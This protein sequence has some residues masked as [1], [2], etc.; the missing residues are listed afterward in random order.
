[1]PTP[2]KSTPPTPALM[3]FGQRLHSPARRHYTPSV[4]L[5]KRTRNGDWLRSYWFLVVRKVTVI[6]EPL[7][8]PIRRKA[9]ARAMAKSP[10]VSP[11]PIVFLLIY[12]SR[13]LALIQSLLKQIGLP[14]ADV[15]FGR[16]TKW[17]P[18][19]PT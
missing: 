9:L 2:Q 12:R 14:G 10:K 4:P 15:R 13:N 17:R 8:A 11:V 6:C 3:G 1:M 5:P 16:L 19:L 7:R 18:I